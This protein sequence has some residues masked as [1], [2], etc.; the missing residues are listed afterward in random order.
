M[1]NDSKRY[2]MVCIECG[3]DEVSRDAW[4]HWDSRT[5]QWVLGAVFN[6]AHCHECEAESSLIEVELS[7]IV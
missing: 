5:Q 2:A 6:Y 3:S 7:P 1:A 4:A